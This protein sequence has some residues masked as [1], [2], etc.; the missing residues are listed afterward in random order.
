MNTPGRRIS[1]LKQKCVKKQH[2]N[3]RN[4]LINT[5]ST[6]LVAENVTSTLQNDQNDLTEEH[7]PNP[8]P[9]VV[10]NRTKLLLREGASEPNPFR[11]EETIILM[12]IQRG[13]DSC[14]IWEIHISD[15]WIPAPS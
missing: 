7:G 15:E 4:G 10:S 2:L 1:L 3:S 13:F 9:E 5:N 11:A 12:T 8:E 6:R 14:H